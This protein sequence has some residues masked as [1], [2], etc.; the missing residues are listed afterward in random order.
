M[1]YL[2]IYLFINFY[3]TLVSEMSLL[4]SEEPVDSSNK[5]SNDLLDMIF[6]EA[7]TTTNKPKPMEKASSSSSNVS[8]FYSNY[9][10]N[11]SIYCNN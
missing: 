8:I 6:D 11:N 9:N 1:L 2:F 10:I 5:N 4:S 7:T 3:F